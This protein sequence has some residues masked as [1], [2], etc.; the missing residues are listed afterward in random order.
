MQRKRP[1]FVLALAAVFLQPGAFAQDDDAALVSAWQ[2]AWERV[3]E[4]AL[5]GYLERAAAGPLAELSPS[6]RDSALDELGGLV[7]EAISWEAFGVSVT[8]RM[9][10]ACDKD[11]LT[12]MKPH[13]G[14]YADG[15]SPEPSVEEAEAYAR[16]AQEAMGQTLQEVGSAIVAKGSEI[17]AVYARYGITYP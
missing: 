1:V 14:G 9:I 8:E 4:R 10:A 2:A 12:V 3:I 5:G 7:Y 17:S 11:L 13:I 16:C 6:E 15:N